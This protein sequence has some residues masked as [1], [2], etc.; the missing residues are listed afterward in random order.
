MPLQTMIDQGLVE[1]LDGL[2]GSDSGWAVAGGHAANVYRLE[3]RF[4]EDVYLLV[5]LG[6]RSMRDAAS[7]LTNQGWTVRT[8][9]SDGWLLRVSHPGFTCSNREP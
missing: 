4:T 8:M 1:L 3:S 2:F 9:M 7:G 6:S 5:S